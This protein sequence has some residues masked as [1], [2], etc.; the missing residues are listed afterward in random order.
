[1]NKTD[2][3]RSCN[4]KGGKEMIRVLIADDEMIE[5]R[6]L[7]TLFG[8]YA[9]TYT[10]VGE[11]KNGREALEKTARLH[12]DV[13]IMDIN[14]SLT[15]GLDAAWQIRQS[16][17]DAIILL[18]TAYAEFEFARKA[19]D[20][21]LDAYLLKPAGEER[22]LQTIQDCV[23]RRRNTGG[24]RTEVRVQQ[25]PE[26]KKDPVDL[27]AAYIEQNLQLPLTLDALAQ[28]A[29]F[30]PTY[31]SRVFHEKKGITVSA[32]ITK[33]RIENAKRLL[34][35]GSMGIQ[36]V[37]EHSGFRTTPHF[38]RMFKQSTGLSP[39][40]YRRQNANGA[41]ENGKD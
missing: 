2:V 3:L 23:K 4:R 35:G 41:H 11:A 28:T 20:Y 27:V 26:P 15:N 16:S 24:T 33:V 13:I 9:G 40:E 8:K 32:Y 12:P 17:P 18:N 34:S 31:L 37:A 38:N 30:S 25:E 19:V 6:Y 1:M 21:R 7:K 36:E 5:R 22:I 10:V 14:M 39:L 29:H